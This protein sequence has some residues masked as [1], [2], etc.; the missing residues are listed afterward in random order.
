MPAATQFLT[1]VL[2]L[3]PSRRKAAA[4]EERCRATFGTGPA[5][6]LIAGRA[7]AD[8]QLMKR[9]CLLLLL[10]MLPFQVAHAQDA[11]PEIVQGKRV[12]VFRDV[13]HVTMENDAGRYDLACNLKVA[14]CIPPAPQQRYYLITKSTQWQMPGAKAPIDLKSV[15]GWTT[16]YPNGEN[17]GLV[18]VNSGPPDSFGMFVLG[19]WSKRL[20]HPDLNQL[21]VVRLPAHRPLVSPDRGCGVGADRSTSHCWDA[22]ENRRPCRCWYCCRLCWLT[23]GRAPSEHI[24]GRGSLR[25][26]YSI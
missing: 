10:L 13:K 26:L 24:K 14:G 19:Y 18:P 8:R 6:T 21:Q 23:R 20:R 15:Q 22:D 7:V 12:E 2:R 4:H 17:I 9:S 1:A 5:G 25:A 11:A 16:N 3:E